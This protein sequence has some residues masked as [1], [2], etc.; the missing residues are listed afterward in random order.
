MAREDQVY[1][2]TTVV[3]QAGTSTVVGLGA[4]FQFV[5]DQEIVGLT[6][7]GVLYAAGFSG[8]GGSMIAAG[9]FIQSAA[10]PLSL[11]AGQVYFTT[12]GNAVFVSVM[13][14]LSQGFSG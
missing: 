14:K 4:S 3:L 9:A 5:L 8:N 13:K 7:A 10:L 2:I 12:T 1:G 6:G 11:G